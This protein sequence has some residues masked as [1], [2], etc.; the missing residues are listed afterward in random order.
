MRYLRAVFYTNQTCTVGDLG[1]GEKNEISQ[2]G[3]FYLK[4]FATNI[5]LSV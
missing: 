5:L 3:V 4:V 2:V 1:S